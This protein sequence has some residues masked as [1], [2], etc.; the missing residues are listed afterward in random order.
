MKGKIKM[1]KDLFGKVRKFKIDTTDVSIIKKIIEDENINKAAREFL[2][3]SLEDFNAH[4]ER[5]KV[6]WEDETLM[7]YNLPV[8]MYLPYGMEEPLKE[9]P[10]KYPEIKDMIDIILR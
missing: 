1:Y 2:K 6:I 8:M 9:I 4:V 3:A 5:K 10:N 7:E